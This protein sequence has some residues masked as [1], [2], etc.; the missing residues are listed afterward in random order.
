[1]VLTEEKDN[2][3]GGES[4]EGVS[5]G[6]ADGG[7]LSFI[8]K[9]TTNV[10]VAECCCIP[11]LITLYEH[12]SCG[13]IQYRRKVLKSIIPTRRRRGGCRLSYGGGSFAARNKGR[14]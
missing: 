10:F 4:R 9:L 7:G 11:P 1:M 5:S 8:D 12:I 13:A 3:K 6:V 14:E 2:D